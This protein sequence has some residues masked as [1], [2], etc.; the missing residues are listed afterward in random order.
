MVDDDENYGEWNG[1]GL[2]IDVYGRLCLLQYLIIVTVFRDFA[3]GAGV[4]L[5]YHTF[6][7]RMRFHI[8][9]MQGYRQLESGM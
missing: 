2:D 1:Y 6:V 4:F 3:A 5:P 8:R 7:L 9:Y